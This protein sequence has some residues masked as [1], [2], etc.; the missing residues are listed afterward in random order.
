MNDASTSKRIR[1]DR[2]CVRLKFSRKV[3]T[4][5]HP[6]SGIGA[7]CVIMAV[8]TGIEPA[9]SRQTIEHSTV[10]LRN[11]GC[12]RRISTCTPLTLPSFTGNGAPLQG[13]SNRTVISHCAGREIAGNPPQTRFRPGYKLACPESNRRIRHGVAKSPRTDTQPPWECKGKHE[14]WWS[15]AD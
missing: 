4:T 6:L 8:T 5:P 7:S 12:T 3:M 14:I 13:T 10:E 2:P 1:R 9:T 15:T 11:L